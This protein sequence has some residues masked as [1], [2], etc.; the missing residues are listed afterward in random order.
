MQFIA[1]YLVFLKIKS[2]KKKK[3]KIIR[4]GGKE[5]SHQFN[6]RTFDMNFELHG[7]KVMIGY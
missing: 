1:I 2:L 7:R 6:G 4:T 3:K 5:F